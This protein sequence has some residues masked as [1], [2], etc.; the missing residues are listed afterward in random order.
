[1]FSGSSH[2]QAGK[3][4]KQIIFCNKLL[5]DIRR[6]LNKLITYIFVR[7]C[8]KLLC[9]MFVIVYRMLDGKLSYRGITFTDT[10]KRQWDL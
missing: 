4:S 6:T 9:D 8:L 10:A 2:L 1:M 3:R 7:H 5:L